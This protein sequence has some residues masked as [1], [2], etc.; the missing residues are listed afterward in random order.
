L[1]VRT[2]SISRDVISCSRS[3]GQFALERLLQTDDL[4]AIRERHALY[5]LSLAEAGEPE[6]KRIDQA[7]WF[8]RLAQE[9]DNMRA[10]LRWCI[11]AQRADLGLRLASALHRYW[12]VRGHWSEGRRW[13]ADLLKLAGPTDSPVSLRA[14]AVAHD[15]EFAYMQ[16]DDAA[17]RPL[18]EEGLAIARRTGER[19]IESTL[20][21][22]LGEVA[23]EAGDIETA[24]SCLNMSLSIKRALGDRYATALGLRSLGWVAYARRT[25][26]GMPV[27]PGG[28]DNRARSRRTGDPAQHPCWLRR[29]GSGTR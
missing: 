16:G 11:D 9:H 3:S 2:L 10:A 17:S 23:L 7:A 21:V 14:T 24:T 12:E 28:A 5:Y 4:E 29:R 13:L 15:G 8:E 20:L 6:L 27:F 19:R 25:F 18:F 1:N 22:G 26:P